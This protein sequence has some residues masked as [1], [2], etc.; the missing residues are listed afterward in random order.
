MNLTSRL[1]AQPEEVARD[2]YSAHLKR[3][4]IIYTKWI[5]KWIMIVIKIIPEW[6]F[7]G[8]SI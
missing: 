6:K 3:K 7:K 8:M 2:I 5:W 4:N 1:T